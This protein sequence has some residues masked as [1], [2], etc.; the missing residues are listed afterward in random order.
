MNQFMSAIILMFLFF[1]F[2]TMST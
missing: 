2:F 1:H